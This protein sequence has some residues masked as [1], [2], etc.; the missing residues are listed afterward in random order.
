MVV[1][2]AASHNR[3]ESHY[4]TGEFKK[5]TALIDDVTRLIKNHADK[6]NGGTLEYLLINNKHEFDIWVRNIE[7]FR[8]SY[9]DFFLEK[10]KEKKVH[11]AHEHYNDVNAA[12]DLLQAE[13]GQRMLYVERIS[14]HLKND[15]PSSLKSILREVKSG[16]NQ[17]SAKM[18]EISDSI[19]KCRNAKG[20]YNV[21]LSKVVK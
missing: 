9:K 13:M 3:I 20:S 16:L 18:I 7:D 2:K 5:F 12:I 4:L 8:A 19:V 6:K 14:D 15:S 11:L 21:K 17:A 10:K 1:H